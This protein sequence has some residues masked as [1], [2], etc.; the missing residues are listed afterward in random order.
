MLTALDVRNRLVL[1]VGG[2]PGAAARASALRA[3]GALVRAVAP[4]LCE[5]LHDLWVDDPEVSWSARAVEAADLDDVWLVSVQDPGM[6]PAVRAWAEQRRVWCEAGT[7]S[8]AAP[9]E[10]V[11]VDGYRLAVTGADEGAARTVRAQVLRLAQEG[12]LRLPTAAPG[13]GKVVLVGGGPG[14]IDLLTV[15]GRRELARADVVVADRLAPTGVLRE[16]AR[17]VEVIDVGKTPY[18]HPIPQPEINRILIER[19]ERGQHVVRL[20]GGDP[21]VLGRGGEEL[22]ACRAAGVDVE[23][24]PGVSSALAAPAA[25]D[26]PVTHRGTTTGFLVI[27]GHDDLETE[28]LARWSGTIVVLMGM[29]RLHELTARLV[30]AG[31]PRSTPAAVIHRAWTPQQRVV[32]GTLADI[33]ARVALAGV[34]NPS[35]IVIGEVAAVMEHGPSEWHLA[36]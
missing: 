29:N 8:T 18:H 28:V 33:G 19:A 12:G 27:S 22:A 3:D 15:R 36:G 30:E 2:G 23:V 20:K 13:R 4:A 32:R 24:V 25:A 7:S 16:L 26:I 10:T 5:D 1:V 9:V 31:K 6:E 34:A 21:F 14:A 11:E 17:D 35:G